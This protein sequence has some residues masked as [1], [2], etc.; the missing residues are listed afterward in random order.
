VLI[1]ASRPS[2]AGLARGRACGFTLIELLVVVSIIGLLVSVLMPALASARRS[3]QGVVCASNLR[4]LGLALE[5]YASENKGNYAPAAPGIATT[6]RVRWFGS[7]LSSG[8]AFAGTG[9]P[10]SDHLGGVDG[11]RRC[12]SLVTGPGGFERAAGGYGYNAAFVGTLRSRGVGGAWVSVSDT[13]GS[14][15]ARFASP[16]ETIGFA[17]CALAIS[18]GA[19]SV[20]EYAFAEPDQWPDAPGSSPDPS[21]HFRHGGSSASALASG[22]PVAQG[23]FLDGHVAQ[24]RRG[25]TSQ[26]SIYASNPAAAGLGWPETRGVNALF[27]YD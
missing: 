8:G 15:Q 9:G 2:R 18:S 16:T 12:A 5:A 7:R 11:V 10:L 27:D 13:T 23:V 25:A 17:D 26:T 20:I 21:V 3:G 24:M 22:S 14:P 6:N 4:Q 1:G 19:A